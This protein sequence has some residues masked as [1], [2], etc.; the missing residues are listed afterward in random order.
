[1]KMSRMLR[2]DSEGNDIIPMCEIADGIVLDN[3]CGECTLKDDCPGYYEGC[4]DAVNGQHAEIDEIISVIELLADGAEECAVDARKSKTDQ[5]MHDRL[6]DWLEE[7]V[8]Y[9]AT[10]SLE[11]AQELAQT[12]RDGRLVVL[13]DVPE[14]DRLSFVGDLKELFD[15]LSNYDPSVGIFGWSEGESR[16]AKALMDVLTR[17]EAEALVSEMTQ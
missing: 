11:R 12:E 13:P 14:K 6:A 17:Q 10:M 1:M 5:K 4:F 7:L 16:L 3:G 9:R 8:A 2:F 15:D